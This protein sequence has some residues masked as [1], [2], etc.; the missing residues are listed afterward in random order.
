MRS[1][2]GGL[3]EQRSSCE[4]EKGPKAGGLPLITLEPLICS[5]FHKAEWMLFRRPHEL[6]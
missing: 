4:L 3:A 6:C 5:P 1:F 2:V